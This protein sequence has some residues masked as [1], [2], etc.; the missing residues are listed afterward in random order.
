MHHLR[1]LV[2][3]HWRNMMALFPH[4]LFFCHLFIGSKFHHLLKVTTFNLPGGPVWMHLRAA[5]LPDSTIRPWQSGVFT[6]G[7]W[8]GL[9]PFKCKCLCFWSA[10]MG[11][12]SRHKEMS[13]LDLFFHAYSEVQSH[14]V[15]WQQLDAILF[16]LYLKLSSIMLGNFSQLSNYWVFAEE[17]PEEEIIFNNPF[18]PFASIQALDCAWMWPV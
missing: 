16:E 8:K 5:C 1:Y 18:I 2:R 3:A 10:T 6:L 14:S 12:L 17:N 11:G 7:T 15:L 13:R 4:K 9:S